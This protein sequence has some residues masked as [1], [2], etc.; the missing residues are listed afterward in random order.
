MK[1]RDALKFGI[2]T[3]VST[4]LGA[5]TTTKS[6]KEICNAL[7]LTDKLDTINRVGKQPRV[8]IIGGGFGGLTTA[9]TIQNN[10]DGAEVMVFD[11]K[12]IFASCPYSNLWIGG[13]DNITYENLVRSP[14]APAMQHDYKLINEKVIVIDRS[15]KFIKTD[16]GCY[17]YNLLVLATGIEY[18][19]APYGLDAKEALLCKNRYPASYK[20]GNEQLMLKEKVENF[21]GGTFVITVPKGGY[22]CPPA[23][24]ERACLIANFF[25]TNKIKA[26]VVVLDPR[27]KPAAKA[28]GFL[29]AFKDYYA[30]FIDYRPMSNISNI[31]LRKKRIIY[32]GFDLKSK[33]FTTQTLGFDDANIIP[34]NRASKL[35]KDSGLAL[36]STGWGRVKAPGF[37][38]YND[39]DVYLVGDVLGEYPFP[40]SGQ[41]A[42]SCAT[43]LGGHIAL[44]LAGKDPK[45][46]EVLPGNVCYSMVTSDKGIA[47]THKAYYSSNEGM[48]TEVELFEDATQN[49]AL[50]T[51]GW[52]TGIMNNIFN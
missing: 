30:D 11:P 10:Y 3:A 44:R 33:K 13:L 36:T 50:A 28:K 23:P 8:I 29:K 51:H 24:Y 22:R 7:N 1:R 39:D 21:T 17:E 14:L 34:S 26:K 18:D 35:L 37:R 12:N 15:L 16:Q 43:I 40:K 5:N 49:T 48:K 41:M 25:K 45:E 47:V 6:D 42:H 46:G 52:Y 2:L 38:S 9:K 32:Q 20:G 4:T 27:E 19:Y 31:D